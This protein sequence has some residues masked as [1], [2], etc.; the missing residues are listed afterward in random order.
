[1]TLIKDLI[2]LPE[3]VHRGDFVLRLSEG[4]ERPDETLR[5]YVVTP[6]LVASFD[7][8]LGFIRS[9]V[10]GR[11]SKAS[12]LHGSFG[13]GKSHFMAILHL[14]LQHNPAARSI[15]ELAP[16]IAKHESWMT[17]RKFLL[18]PYH[19]I[20]ARSMESAILGHYVEHVRKLHPEAPVPGVYLSEGLFEDAAGL[21]REFGDE[22]FFARL[23]E[24]AA[25]EAGGGW[26][27]LAAGWTAQSYEA[28]AAAPP[29][30]ED[31]SRL[32][33]ALVRRFFSSYQGLAA[34]DES[35][36]VSLDQGLSVISRHARSLGYDAI[37]L[38]LDELI[39][40]LASHAADISFVNREG[41]KLAKLVEAQSP[42]RPIP[43]VSFVARQRDLRE[44]VGE[45]VAG[46]DQL[47]FADVL[48]YWEA[49]FHT[50]T[51][52]D[53]NLPA[54]AEKRVLRPRSESAR[55]HLDQA[56]RETERIREDVMSVLLTSTAD[57]D[58]FRKVYPFS[59]ALVQV[60]VA[61]SAVLQRERT[62]L[63]V[64][65]QL[66][67]S[68]R[69]QLKLGDV[70]PVG[71]LFD[72]IAEGDEAFSEG[73]SRHF[74]NAK[75]LYHQKLLPLLEH[76]H[77]V[78]ADAL[79]EG[80][81]KAAAFRTDD[82]LVK[83]LLL[84]ALVPEVEALRALT[85]ARLAALNHGTIRSP[86]PGRESS[87]VLS[88]CRDWAAQ[89]GEIRISDDANPTISVQLSG[90]D[91]DTILDKAKV[92]DNFANRQR[93]VR[94]V[95]FTELGLEDQ[96]ELFLLHEFQWRGT[97]RRCEVLFTNV[98]D[99]PDES[100]RSETDWRIVIDFPFD[101]QGHTAADDIARLQ[102]FTGTNRS[103]RAV[104]WMPAFLAAQSLKELGTYCIL[105]HVLLGERFN[106]YATH[107]S[108]VDRA[109]ARALLENQR[110]QLRQRLITVLQGAY[111]IAPPL[112]GSVDAS[113]FAG[114]ADQLIS[115]DG[116][117]RPQPPVGANMGQALT[118][119]L[120]QM[121]AHQFPAHPAFEAEIKPAV[122]RKV[123]EEIRGATQTEDGR[124]AVDKPLRALVRQVANP[125]QLGT[126]HETHFVLAHH[127]PTHFN[128]K[129][130]EA[131]VANPSVGH[132]R[133]WIDQPKVMGLPRDVQNIIVLVF[134]D[135]TNRSF[136][137]HGGPIEPA[138]DN[139]T[140][141]MEL[142][143]EVLPPADLWD[144]ARDRAS[145]I[146][147]FAS[148][149]L[150]NATNVSRLSEDLARQS[151]DLRDPAARL[152]ARL[153]ERLQGLGIEPSGSARLGTA[154]AALSLIESILSPQSHG[155]V[156]VL[157]SATI[158]SSDQALGRSLKSAAQVLGTLESTNWDV[159]DAVGRLSDERRAAAAGIRQ[160]VSEAL[161]HDEI[162]QALGPV[163]SQA[164]RDALNLLVDT[165][166]PA[167]PPRP[168]PPPPPPVAGE[169]V[170]GEGDAVL[171][172][173]EAR[174]ALEKLQKQLAD[175]PQA[176]LELKWRLLRRK[177]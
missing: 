152:L 174:V 132:L 74:A 41:Q 124:M 23:N 78:R 53:R 80:D 8:A 114:P 116:T 172:A 142:K 141:E 47:G 81:A 110:S 66:L 49:R 21:R 95:L 90:V 7:N 128:R 62:A 129:M 130:S 76:Q 59:P 3:Q 125:L 126:M 75:R 27:D 24:G 131:G 158:P 123:Y 79:V 46:A 101:D 127:W 155:V 70:V 58:M 96:D 103:S 171:S 167:D 89:V 40:W 98:R 71:D 63:K 164:Q 160:R 82:R 20:G 177:R 138:L 119:L 50:L 86:I 87:I 57:R 13:S 104:V 68:Q 163:L 156:A 31:R 108:A 6:Q 91:T 14:L 154:S 34:G 161:G 42:D 19:M 115:L 51:L 2:E 10:D 139:L 17:G 65:L 157:A 15:A 88:K 94:E 140:D 109:A 69:D 97:R 134:A 4:V 166:K 32:V 36:F 61:V 39:L 120:D 60:L 176:R 26:G 22:T 102:R 107:L 64:M 99:L 5:Q 113:Q 43:I 173:G 11:S 67:V 169:E 48:K 83:T 100:L 44:L 92:N 45:H 135:Q 28:A 145:T 35:A 38:F 148:S 1:M 12:Y 85:P 52:E 168:A 165:G 136:Y 144:K 162:A 54:I 143:E 37:V 16:L 147:G 117:F 105:E 111:G 133:A 106:D 151:G 175:E 30:A 118:H 112:P 73:M 121:L 170:L 159:F 33:G 72:V 149:P 9:A 55:Q 93:R 137:R 122:L 18:V 146:F 29:D 77:E 153:R 25:K 150:R 84:A 56:F